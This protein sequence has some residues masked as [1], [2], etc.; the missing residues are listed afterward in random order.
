M[1][2]SV[3]MARYLRSQGLRCAFGLPGGEAIPI[4]EALRR[5]DVPFILTHHESPAGYMAATTALFTGVPGLCLATRG[6]GAANMVSAV[7]MAYL[8]RLPL[9]AISGD[10]DPSQ[11]GVY[12]HSVLDLVA[13]FQPI[14]KAS[15]RLLAGEIDT[16]LPRAFELARSGRPGPVFFALSVAEANRELPHLGDMSVEEIGA[17]YGVAREPAPLPD[18]SGVVDALRASRSP[19]IMAGQGVVYSRSAVALLAAAEHLRAPVVVMPQAK[20]H[21]PEDHPLFA[22]AYG[23]CSDPPLM[24]LVGDADLVLAVGLDGVEFFRVWNVPTPVVSVAPAYADDPTYSPRVAVDGEL[25]SILTEI[26]R[27]V[28]PRQGW[29]LARI[30]RC[31]QEIEGFLAPRAVDP[32]DCVMP[33]G[34][35]EELRAV[36]PRDG[37]LSVD[38]GSHKQVAIAQWRAYEPRTFLN[39]NGLSSMGSAISSAIAAKLACPD[40]P[41]VALTGD[42]GLLMFAGELETIARLGLPV[43]VVVMNDGGLSTIR[44]KQAKAGFPS[45]GVEFGSPDYASLARDFGLLGLRARTREECRN[46]F[47]RAL[48]SGRGAVVEVMTHFDEY[49][50]A[51]TR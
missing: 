14:T 1:R 5:E 18:L 37:I 12:S 21:F 15:S 35:V 11:Y 13:L 33:Q 40:Q 6:P 44:V 34:V 3:F 27:E 49:L 47:A 42:G 30:A 43:T 39:T 17:R 41:V 50:R 38:V 7:A 28:E 22:G 16:A 10:L 26:V 23:V 51:D 9:L 32:E 29:T 45:V 31:R 8:D 19:V 2:A 4:L 24:K 48:E 36:L 46:A 25:P 20:G